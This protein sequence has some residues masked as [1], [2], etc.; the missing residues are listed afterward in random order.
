ML[1]ALIHGFILSLGLILPIGVQNVFIFNQGATQPRFVSVLPVVITASIC[2][3]A[4]VVAAVLGVSVIVMGITW[5]KVTLMVFGIMFLIYMGY[6]TWNNKP[7][8]Q[9][10]Q[11]SVFTTKKQ[12]MF[13]ASV[14][15]L[16]PHAILDTVGVIGTSSLRYAG[17]EKLAFA[18]AC[19]AVSWIWF[20]GLAIGGRLTGESINQV[21]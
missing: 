15:L 3:T 8:N 20:T 14:S 11:G 13:A 10:A 6:V 16:N 17:M 9:D 5:L 18:A 21:E 19:I 1:A 12:I 2:D 7:Q 4:L